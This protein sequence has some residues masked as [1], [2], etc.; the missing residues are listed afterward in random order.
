MFLKHFDVFDLH[1]AESVNAFWEFN[2][3][4]LFN[5]IRQQ[6]SPFSYIG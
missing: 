2:S 3:F 4:G 6:F 1:K 5:C